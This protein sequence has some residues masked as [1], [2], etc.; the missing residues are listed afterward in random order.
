MLYLLYFHDLIQFATSGNIKASTPLKQGR[1]EL[2]KI[3][4]D[5]LVSL[6]W[7]W[8]L[9]L[10]LLCW[11]ILYSTLCYSLFLELS[12]LLSHHVAP[13]ELII[14]G[15]KVWL[16]TNS[17]SVTGY[18]LN[19][20]HRAVSTSTVSLTSPCLKNAPTHEPWCL[21]TSSK[22]IL[23]FVH[24]MKTFCGEVLDIKQTIHWPVAV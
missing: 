13:V 12:T 3:R 8:L 7:T 20:Q 4:L 24:V 17:F 11:L 14:S 23:Q 5:K 18:C 10:T 15:G 1:S 16:R 9:P 6:R 22:Q 2:L 19:Q 21:Q